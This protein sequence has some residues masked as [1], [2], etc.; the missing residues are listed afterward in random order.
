MRARSGEP[1]PINFRVTE[2]EG[3]VLDAW[4]Y[5][6]DSTPTEVAR[7]ELR[8]L[9]ERARTDPRVQRV[10]RERAEVRAERSGTL[11]PLRPRMTDDRTQ[12]ND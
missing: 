6:Q 12:G 7:A 11:T 1:R 9:I 10:L 2:E 5:L 8:A 3:D 4:A